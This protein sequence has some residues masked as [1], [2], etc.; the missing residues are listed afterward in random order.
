MRREHAA[1]LVTFDGLAALRSGWIAS[2]DGLRRHCFL[3]WLLRH[4]FFLD[5]DQGFARNTIQNVNPALLGMGRQCMAHF[6]VVS[7][8]EQDER[9]GHIEIPKIVMN[10]L[11]VPA[12]ASG[13]GV[14]RNNRAC[15]QIISAARGTVVIRPGISCVHINEPQVWI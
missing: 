5:V 8:V 10:R 1:L 3:A 4:W 2:W 12:I 14:Q 15:E 7:L 11:I 13:G 6:S 9:R